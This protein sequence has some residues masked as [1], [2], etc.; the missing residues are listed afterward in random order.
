MWVNFVFWVVVYG[1]CDI[2]LVLVVFDF[3]WFFDWFVVD[4]LVG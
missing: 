2:V 1:M 3:E 4:L